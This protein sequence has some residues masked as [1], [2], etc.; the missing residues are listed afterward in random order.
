MYLATNP[1]RFP[2]DISDGAVIC[3]DDLAQIFRVESRRERCRADEIAEHHRQLAAFG[4]DQRSEVG[5][6]ATLAPD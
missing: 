2:D 5:A 6:E 4:V 1:S 3:G